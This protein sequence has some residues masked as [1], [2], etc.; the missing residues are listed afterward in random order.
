MQTKEITLDE[1]QYKGQFNLELTIN[2]GQTSQPPWNKTKD[3]HYQEILLIDN[4]PILTNIQQ[5]NQQLNITYKTQNNINEEQ[6]LEK[7]Y[8]IFDLNYNLEKLYNTLKKDEKLYNTIKNN[9]GLRLYKAQDP[10]EC[11][12][13]SIS[14][15][16]NSI[17]RW[18]QSIKKLR[19]QSN[20]KY[21]IEQN[22]HYLFPTKQHILKQGQKKLEETG[23]GYRAPY[24]IE[25]TKTLQDT[26]L[27]EKIKNLD[28]QTSYNQLLKLKGIGSKVADCILLYGY[29]KH[30]AYPVDIWINR[31][32]TYLY[33]ENKKQTNNTIRNF[34]M[35]KFKK[36]AGYTQLYLFNYARKTGLDQKI[37][38]LIK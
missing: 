14:S 11:I 8:Y 19:Q 27:D 12:I 10:Y 32:T 34:A 5:K 30:E 1:N 3:N 37:K 24:I 13:S 15:A 25:T 33:F 35:K 17:K 16:N 7:I 26:K 29:G 20:K 38:K 4:Q 2:T 22:T 28:Y 31:I 9:E 18:T 36:T 23:L 21:K 6:L